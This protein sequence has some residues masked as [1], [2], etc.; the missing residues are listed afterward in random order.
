MKQRVMGF[1]LA[2]ALAIFG[3]VIVNFKTVM[4]AETGNEF[5]L[6]FATLF[7]GRASALFVILAGV[8]VTFLT[9]KARNSRDKVVVKTSRVSLIKRALLLITIGLI[10]TPIWEADILHFYGFYFL[11]GATVFM[12]SN[13]S[14]LL[15][16]VVITLTF[17]TLML[18]FDYDQ[19]WHWSTLTYMN[20][21]S[22]DGMVRHVFF[23]GF[24]PVFPWATF[25][26]F[27]MWL[28][29]FDLSQTTIRNQLLTWS[30]ITLITTETLF[31][32]VRHYLTDGLSFGIS[33]KDVVLLFSITIIP[34][35]PQYII[36][37]GSSA[38]IVLVGCLYFSDKFKDSNINRWLCQTGQL[39]LTLYVAHVILGMSVLDNIN[40]LS[41][42]PIGFSLFSS[43]IFCICGVAF[44]VFWFKNFK[45]GPLESIFRKVAS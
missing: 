28:G 4:N 38:C 10:Y 3:M 5:L 14:L 34:P 2:R 11:I 20:L 13:R 6:W 23:N 30:V 31:Y 12:V 19:N 37:A 21:W 27:G 18:F 26:I 16:S 29:R 17:P 45:V 25:L 42:Q 40:R 8:G 1:D 32:L 41:N 9:N 36:S 39:S 24:H 15:V 22:F 43:L 44:S 7:E 33:S 35:L